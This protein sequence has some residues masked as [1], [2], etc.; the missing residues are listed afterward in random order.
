[1]RWLLIKKMQQRANK[2]IINWTT[3]LTSIAVAI[4]CWVGSLVM[5][6]EGSESRTRNDIQD[7]RLNAHDINDTEMKTDIKFI[8]EDMKYVKSWVEA[9]QRSENK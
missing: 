6:S 3:F 1:M 9:Q 4:V 5:K 8:L 7:Q 2:I